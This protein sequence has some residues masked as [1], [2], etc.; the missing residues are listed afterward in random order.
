MVT[1][2]WDES[3]LLADFFIWIDEGKIR[4]RGEKSQLKDLKNT[5]MSEL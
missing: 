1:H 4:A 3:I 2:D 5:Y